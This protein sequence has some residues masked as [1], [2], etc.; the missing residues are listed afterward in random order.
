MIYRFGLGFLKLKE[1][2]LINAK[3]G[4]IG[5]MTEIKELLNDVDVEELFKVSFGFSI[6]REYIKKCEEEFNNVKDNKE[7]EIMKMLF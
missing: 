7:H 1:D 4:L 2:K 3:N 6:S 5:L